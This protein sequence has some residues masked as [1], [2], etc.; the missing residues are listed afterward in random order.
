M[1]ETSATRLETI[2][3]IAWTD[4]LRITPTPRT[5]PDPPGW[6]CCCLVERATACEGVRPW[7]LIP[8]GPDLPVGEV[9]ARELAQALAVGAQL[10]EGLG[11]EGRLHVGTLDR[12]AQR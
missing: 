4:E 6:R 1:I 3:E 12:P 5:A 2:R 11:R 7:G 10:L 9:A 8:S